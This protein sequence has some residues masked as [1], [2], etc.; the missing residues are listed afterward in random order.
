MLLLHVNKK[1]AGVLPGTIKT[2]STRRMVIPQGLKMSANT[3]SLGHKSS[4][5]RTRNE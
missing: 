4:Q 3:F 1:F 5:E 2:I